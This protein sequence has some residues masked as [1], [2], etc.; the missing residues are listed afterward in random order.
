M[1]V[2][3]ASVL[4]A[5]AEIFA[6]GVLGTVI[7]AIDKGVDAKLQHGDTTLTVGNLDDEEKED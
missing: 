1:G 4:K 6:F 2:I 5:V 7:K 3:D